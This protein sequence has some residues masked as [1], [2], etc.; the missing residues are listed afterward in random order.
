MQDIRNFMVRF[1]KE[2]IVNSQY[3]KKKQNPRWIMSH[4][5]DRNGDDDTV[6]SI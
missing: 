5:K 6:T 2:Q 4:F 1:S 3:R